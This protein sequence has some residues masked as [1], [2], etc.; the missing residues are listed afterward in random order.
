MTT[1]WPVHPAPQPGEALSSWLWRLA[2]ALDVDLAALCAD[3]GWHRVDGTDVDRTPPAALVRGLAARTSVDS[4]TITAMSIAGYCPW[5]TDAPGPTGTDGFNIYT[6]QLSVLIAPG[7]RRRRAAPSWRAWLPPAPARPWR[8]CPSCV[9]RSAGAGERQPYQLWWSVPLLRSCPE[10]Q[11]LL[12]VHDLAPGFYPDRLLAA[13]RS[14]PA[15]VQTMDAYTAQ[16][17]GYGHVD[18]PRRRVHAGIWFRLLRTILDE[19]GATTA[20]CGPA[21]AALQEIWRQAG[22]RWRGGHTYWHPYETLPISS[23]HAYLDAAATAI[24]GLE[25]DW[26]TGAGEH[27]D[28]F[29]PEPYVPVP[30]YPA[31]PESPAPVRPSLEASMG[32]IMEQLRICVD[33]ARNDP[34][35]AKQFYNAVTLGLDTPAIRQ[36]FRASFTELGI[37]V[38]FLPP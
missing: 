21:T 5:L 13:P 24:G 6:R 33:L 26:V 4:A 23:Q 35:E 14:A 3:A 10:H 25:R 20:E 32:S 34:N 1:R 19:L 37:P 16:A 38:D 27:A 31:P 11:C 15:T 8:V 36:R 29:R 30:G 22:Y 28:L 7:R 9:T 2:R 12:T 18:L 17:L